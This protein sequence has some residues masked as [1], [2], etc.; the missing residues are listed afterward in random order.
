[1][2]VHCAGYSIWTNSSFKAPLI[3]SAVACIL[4]NA[5]YCLGYDTKWLYMLMA[6]RLVT[7]LGKLP[8]HWQCLLDCRWLLNLMCICV[9][10]HVHSVT[11][12]QGCLIQTE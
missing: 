5:L 4:G 9:A 2:A 10:L 6:A 11:L 7:G 8:C 1:M 12:A 3:C